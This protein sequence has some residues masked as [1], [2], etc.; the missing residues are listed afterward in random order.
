MTDAQI[1]YARAVFSLALEKKQENQTLDNLLTF[2]KSLTNQDW[3]FFLHPK[4]TKAEKH[5]VLEKLNL[6]LL[7]LNFLKVLVDNDRLELL[8]LIIVNYQELLN[9]L[10]GFALVKVTTKV[11]LSS[12][13]LKKLEISL[14]QRLNKEIKLEEIIDDTLGG[15]I[16]LEYQGEVI[17][18]SINSL[19]N[20]IKTQLT[21][22]N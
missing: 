16:K 8:D 2:K 10:K 12:S 11:K 7:V 6:D 1:Q 21:G 3:K 14:N 9:E 4:I 18:L 15:G 5:Q 17:D 19:I 13:N 20:D 22:G